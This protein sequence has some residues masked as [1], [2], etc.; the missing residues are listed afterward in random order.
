MS[1][2]FVLPPDAR[3]R[4]DMLAA[5]HARSGATKHRGKDVSEDSMR[6]IA[7]P[8]SPEYSSYENQDRFAEQRT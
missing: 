3:A 6:G 2:S 7:T 5:L 4:M 8:T 1:L